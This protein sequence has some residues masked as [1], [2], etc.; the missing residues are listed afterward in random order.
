MRTDRVPVEPTL[1]LETTANRPA[2]V[3]HALEQGVRGIPGIKEPRGQA[4]TQAMVGVAEPLQG[5]G[6]L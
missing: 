1:L 3:T 2:I 6:R 5:Q 4:T